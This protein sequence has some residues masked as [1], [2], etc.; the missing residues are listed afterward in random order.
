LG[1]FL[2]VPASTAIL[3]SESCGTH[4]PILLF[5]DS[6]S[7]A[8]LFY[9]NVILQHPVALHGSDFAFCFYAVYVQ[10]WPSRMTFMGDHHISSF[11]PSKDI[12]DS[13]SQQTKQNRN[14][15]T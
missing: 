5:H 4:D 3:I 12:Q 15:N 13:H 2:L 7:R 9:P 8:T 6:G 10:L 11:H 1:K 14:A